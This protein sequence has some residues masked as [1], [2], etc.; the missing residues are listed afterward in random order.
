M[1]GFIKNIWLILIIMFAGC[2]IKQSDLPVEVYETS[3][4]GHKLEKITGFSVAP[5]PV[6]VKLFPDE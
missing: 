3:S 5:D 2:S 6:V 4:G 1:N